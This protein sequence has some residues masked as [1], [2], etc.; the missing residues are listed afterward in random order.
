[1]SR[2]MLINNLLGQECRI[3]VVD[4]GH[5]QELYVERASNA[6]RVGNIY[7]GKVTNVEPGIQAA[8]VDFGAGKNGFLHISDVHPKYF[9]K[10]KDAVEAVGRKRSQR[11]RPPIQKCF[12]R[13][14]EVL[15]QLIKEGIGTKG[16]TLTTYLS[17]PG[18]LLVMMPGMSKLGVS[19]KIEDEETRVKAR[20]ILD[21]LKLPDNMGFI[22]RTAGMD[23]SKRAVQQDLNYL[24]RLWKSIEKHASKVKAPAEVYRESDLIIRTIRDIYNSDIKR[25]I[26]DGLADARKV[27]EFV[28]VVMPRRKHRID[29]YTGTED[30]FMAAGLESEIEKM[31]SRVVDLPSGGSLVFDQTEA[32]VAVDVNSGK[33]REHS[34][35]ETTA[36]KTNLEAAAEIGRQ[37]RIRDMGGMV[38]IDFIDL[39]QDK[40][41]QQVEKA[42][43]D[44]IKPDRAKT[45]LL[46]MNQFGLLEMTRQRLR[47]SLKQSLYRQC[48]HCSGTGL[49]KSEESQTIEMMRVLQSMCSDDRV[50]EIELTVPLMVAEYFNNAMRRQL[51]ELEARTGRHITVRSGAALKDGE[52][53]VVCRNARGSNVPWPT[54]EGHKKKKSQTSKSLDGLAVVDINKYK[55]EGGTASTDIPEGPRT[56]GGD[57]PVTGDMVASAHDEDDDEAPADDPTPK[58]AKKRRRRRKS[59][60]KTE[61]E[62]SPSEGDAEAK[63]APTD[64]AEA[65]ADEGKATA[66]DQSASA[67]DAPAKKKTS[68][69]RRKSSKKAA[70]KTD[71]TAEAGDDAK[72]DKASAETSAET[73]D[74]DTPAGTSKN[75]STE[76][77]KSKTARKRT[78]KKSAKKVAV[79][80]KPAED[81]PATTDDD[82]GEPAELVSIRDADGKIKGAAEELDSGWPIG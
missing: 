78:R 72:A 6:S 22:I 45:R 38:V 19:R 59:A 82:S 57:A 44:A 33:M 41:R 54:G 9:P 67:Q 12:K 11:H 25:I 16:A 3:A 70:T 23:Q 58:K 53:E 42:L 29:I 37:L 28:S 35:A 51:C 34:D 46:K 7:K 24:T 36:L 47:P 73:P 31:H 61:G 62:S 17:I 65:K 2:E 60:K 26:C 21:E 81:A 43:K 52:M 1:M 8:F 69:R 80:A 32:L 18:R 40:H 4:G 76:K 79:K 50:A 27:A 55:D 48:E 56:S 75:D 63:S 49:V 64:T 5:L 68:R 13:G 39:Y 10:E 71:E 15:V 66:A 20:A 77:P 74:A 14:Q 30:L